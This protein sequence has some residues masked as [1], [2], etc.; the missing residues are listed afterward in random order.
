MGGWLIGEVILQEGGSGIRLV[1]AGR[2]GYHVV[3]RSCFH[4]SQPRRNGL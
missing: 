1:L 2:E 3:E 4:R